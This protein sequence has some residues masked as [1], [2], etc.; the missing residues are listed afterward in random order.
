MTI[1]A[2]G[3]G[4]EDLDG[5]ARIIAA[6]YGAPLSS[7]TRAQLIAAPHD[8]LLADFNGA[9]AGVVL[10]A[11]YGDI[12]YVGSMAVD[13]ALRRRGI[14][15]ALMRELLSRCERAGVTALALDATE[16]GAPLYREFGFEQTDVTQIFE[17]TGTV[18]VPSDEGRPAPESVDAALAVDRALVGWRRDSVLKALLGIGGAKLVRAPDGFAFLRSTVV[19]PWVAGSAASAEQ[20]LATCIAGRHEPLRAFVPGCNAAAGEML[21]RRGFNRTRLLRHMTRGEPAPRREFIYGQASLA[22]G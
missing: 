18:A 3:F 8:I 2:R 6:A 13:P 9:L 1:A 14:A 17:R 16:S 4:P 19:G 15:R 11:N 20:L 22:H 10:L 12:A 21:R 5:L 7:A